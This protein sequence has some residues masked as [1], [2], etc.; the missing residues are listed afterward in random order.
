MIL[1]QEKDFS[2]ATDLLSEGIVLFPGHKDLTVCMGVCLM[3]QG[4]F[5]DALD[6]FTPFD[7]DPGLRQYM[8]ICRS[9]I[10]P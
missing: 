3:N 10:T 7:N 6:H 5:K 8:D 2:R 9:R 4:R 1:Q